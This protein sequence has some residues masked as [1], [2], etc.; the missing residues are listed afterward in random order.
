[1]E[2]SV[3]KNEIKEGRGIYII[4]VDKDNASTI[5]GKNYFE[6]VANAIKEFLSDEK[7]S[8]SQDKYDKGNRIH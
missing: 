8:A 1:M 7:P 5:T 4:D 2:N 6:R 3:I